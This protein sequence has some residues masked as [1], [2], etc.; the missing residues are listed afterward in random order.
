MMHLK[1]SGIGEATGSAMNSG[2]A[3]IW[4]A[5]PPP[6]PASYL[7]PPYGMR[8]GR[9]AR[10]PSGAV[11]LSSGRSSCRPAA[12]PAAPAAPGA[13][14]ADFGHD[15]L[16]WSRVPPPRGRGRFVLAM[17]GGA[18]LG[19]ALTVSLGVMLPDRGS[20]FGH[21][22]QVS[23]PVGSSTSAPVDA[24]AAVAAPAPA[25]NRSGAAS[26]LAPAVPV[27]AIPTVTP[28]LHRQPDTTGV[29]IGKREAT[30]P[31]SVSTA[32][33]RVS[34]KP[35]AAAQADWP[36]LAAPDRCG[37]DWPCGD[38]LRLLR[39]ELKR[40]EA[41]ERLPVSLESSVVGMPVLLMEHRRVTEWR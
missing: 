16:A 3:A 7:P 40:R 23:L 35:R 20:V 5:L 41:H 38:E 36:A 37:G 25:V 17:I 10:L 15:N 34:V 11:Y 39:S 27:R 1:V 33:P 12:A 31:A 29:R 13:R 14:A 4:F 8:H 19:A 24:T 6:R 30:R 2:P 18:L 28:T 9:L 26:D 21:A 22:A 32:R